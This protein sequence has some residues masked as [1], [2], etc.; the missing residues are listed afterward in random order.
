MKQKINRI[1]GSYERQFELARQLVG[2]TIT[3][4]C[5]YLEDQDKDFTEQPNDFGKSLLN[6]IDIRTSELTFSI[7][8][9]FIDRSRGL[10]MD[11]GQTTGHE[12][13]ES[14]KKPVSFKSKISKG[15]INELNLY[16]MDIPYENETG[17]YLQE[18]ELKTENGYL[19]VSSIE[20]TGGVVGH[21]FTDELLVI[22]IPE[23][24]ELLELGQFGIENERLT[25]KDW[26]EMKKSM[27]AR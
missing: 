23:K 20:V 14:T 24:A 15:K 10:S 26:D 1:I 16:W 7:G 18:I 11:M 22:D 21:E 25:F 4:V 17:L 2:Q 13:L 8:N 6:G 3:D 5:F 9:R 27:A 12:F 19:L